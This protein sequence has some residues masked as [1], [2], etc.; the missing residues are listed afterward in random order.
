LTIVSPS[1]NACYFHKDKM[2]AVCPC[3][4]TTINSRMFN[5]M[6]FLLSSDVSLSPPH[7]SHKQKHN[8]Q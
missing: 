8:V 3:I 6:G 7:K 1:A 5:A 4:L 2:Q